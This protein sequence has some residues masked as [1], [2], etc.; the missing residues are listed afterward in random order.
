[1]KTIK[2]VILALFLASSPVVMAQDYAFKVLAHKGNSEVKSGSAWEPLKTGTTL[3]P[4]DEV[5]LGEN[6]YVGLV[7][8]SGKPVEVKESG[9][10]KVSELEAK[11]PSGSSVLNK[12]TDFILS[13]NDDLRKNRQTA[14]G[15]I[16]RTTTPAAPG[17]IKVFLPE[18]TT[19]FNKSV[20]VSWEERANEGPYV[21]RV[22]NM[23]EDVLH[24]AETSQNS[25]TIDLTSP[26]VAK[27]P[28][29]LIEVSSKDKKMVSRKHMIRQMT[30]TDYERIASELNSIKQEISE[31]NALSKVLV[32]GFYENNNLLAD[33]ILAYEEAVRLQ[34]EAFNEAYEEFMIRNNL[35]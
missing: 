15:A 5:K 18:N 22:M 17:A 21:V 32:A 29:I 1:M 2:L 31:E 7:H 8:A 14:T 16:T 27:E 4:G 35:K 13:S 11:V 30:P 3:Q 19:V 10:H 25:Y 24:K 9:V 34:P 26:K 28:A 6:A 23:F 20:I 12:Y 33:A